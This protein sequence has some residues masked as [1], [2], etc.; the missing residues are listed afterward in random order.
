MNEQKVT[1]HTIP[2]KYADMNTAD[3]AATVKYICSNARFFYSENNQYDNQN[4]KN[5]YQIETRFDAKCSVHP[6]VF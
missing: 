6:F 2:S 3:K 5:W 4:L 1:T